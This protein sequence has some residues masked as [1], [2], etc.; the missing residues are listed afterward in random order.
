MNKKLSVILIFI[1]LILIVSTVTGCNSVKSEYDIPLS[2]SDDFVAKI[3]V[4]DDTKFL[5]STGCTILQFE[6][7][8]SES[9][10][11][12]F[13]DDYF[14]ALEIVFSTGHASN[15]VDY[16]YDKDQRMIFFDLYTN[17]DNGKTYFTLACD[18]CENIN[19]NEYWTIEKSS[20]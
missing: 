11:K 20:N 13:Y 10:V 4:P 7:K 2:F 16:Y 14:S 18:P 8:V 1:S 19:D 6:T 5:G 9:E 3:K 15:E 17:T 12:E